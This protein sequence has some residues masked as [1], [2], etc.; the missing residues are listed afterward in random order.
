MTIGRARARTIAGISTKGSLSTNLFRKQKILLDNILSRATTWTAEHANEI[1]DASTNK[2]SSTTNSYNE[3]KTACK[4]AKSIAYHVTRSS[5]LGKFLGSSG[6]ATSD[7]AE[8]AALAVGT[9]T[10]EGTL[11]TNARCA[12]T[13]YVEES[14]T[15][16]ASMNDMEENVD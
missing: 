1:T 14:S 15:K 9:T 16:H 13:I 6:T 8:A 11:C 2:L 4:N 10:V 7:A 12:N 5:G 3:A